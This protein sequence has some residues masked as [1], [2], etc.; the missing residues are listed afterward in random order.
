MT[1]DFPLFLDIVRNV[2]MALAKADFSIARLYASLVEDQGL[3]ERVFSMLAPNSSSP[4][5]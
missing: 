4:A 5:R 3:R 2:E 1:R